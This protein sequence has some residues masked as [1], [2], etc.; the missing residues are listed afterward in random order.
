MSR[1]ITLCTIGSRGDCQPYVALGLSLK[2]RGHTVTVATE[3][4][5]FNLIS[6]FGLNFKCV[7]GDSCG[8]LYESKYQSTL[9][10]GS[11]IGLINMTNDWNSKFDKKEILQSYVSALSGADIIISGALTLTQTFCVAEANKAVWIPMIL[12]PTLTTSEFPLW[13]LQAITCGCSCLN[14]WTYNLAFKA[15]WDQE[16]VS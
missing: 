2:A 9:K 14:K 8:M 16:K 1:N 15:L 4:R 7:S 11:F 6:E 13:A 10:S 5:N 12:G 3:Q